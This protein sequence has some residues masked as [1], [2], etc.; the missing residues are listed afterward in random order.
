MQFLPKNKSVVECA[1]VILKTFIGERCELRAAF[2]SAFDQISSILAR[3]WVW[4][5][6]QEKKRS[7][8]VCHHSCWR[9]IV[10]VFEKTFTVMVNLECA[11]LEVSHG[12]RGKNIVDL[13]GFCVCGFMCW[14]D[15]VLGGDGTFC[16]V[17][18]WLC[19]VIWRFYF[20]ASEEDCRAAKSVLTSCLFRF[21]SRERFSFKEVHVP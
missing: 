14:C 12:S 19:A 1:I 13:S 18:V 11:R 7:F 3:F 20:G 17:L 9:V 8:L 4:G 6:K 5:E 15:R 2:C 21:I 10:I 16:S